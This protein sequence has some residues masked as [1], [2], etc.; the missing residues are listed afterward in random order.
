MHKNLIEVFEF[1]MLPV[2]SFYFID[3]ELCDFNLDEYMKHPATSLVGS[4]SLN[5]TTL[6]M[7]RAKWIWDIM[8]DITCGLAFIHSEGKVH[9]DIKPRNS[10]VPFTICINK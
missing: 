9:R 5:N 8:K 1:G 6:S 3:M 10:G 2:G 7:Q 4:I